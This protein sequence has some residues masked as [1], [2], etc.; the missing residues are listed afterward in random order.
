MTYSERELRELQ[1][2]RQLTD[3]LFLDDLSFRLLDSGDALFKHS[4]TTSLENL[5]LRVF[6]FRHFLDHH[7]VIVVSRSLHCRQQH[8]HIRLL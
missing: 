3:R 5:D 8:H 6:F 1:K 7:R 2:L 4:L